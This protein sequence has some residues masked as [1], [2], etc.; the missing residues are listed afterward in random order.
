MPWA[1][2]LSTAIKHDRDSYH[3]HLQKVGIA[4][5]H[6][7]QVFPPKSRPGYPC[8]SCSEVGSKENC[9]ET[10]RPA[11]LYKQERPCFSKVGG[12]DPLLNLSLYLAC[13]LMYTHNL[14]WLPFSQPLWFVEATGAGVAVRA[15]RALGDPVPMGV[16]ST[17]HS[18]RSQ[19]AN[20]L[21]R[22]FV[23]TC[24]NLEKEQRLDVS[25]CLSS[26]LFS[27]N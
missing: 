16:K 11:G 17:E 10:S 15:G 20:V 7:T 2:R 23:Q 25:Q 5:C 9:I 4:V 24:R 1:W 22:I 26:S 21:I 6:V 18:Q 19:E 3:G 14:K 8:P 27:M 13:A 12:E